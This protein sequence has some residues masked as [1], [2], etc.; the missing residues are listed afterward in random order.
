MRM[1]VNHT[2]AQTI[3]HKTSNY[4][5]RLLGGI[6]IGKIACISKDP[7]IK[8]KSNIFVHNISFFAKGIKHFTGRTCLRI[9]PVNITKKGITNMMVDIH[10]TAYP[11]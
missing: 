4:T 11:A 10:D 2:R 1:F 3:V 7:R 5:V 9:N 8:A 6:G